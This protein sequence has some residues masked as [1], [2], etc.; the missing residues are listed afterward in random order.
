MVLF[1]S[2]D[3]GFDAGTSDRRIHVVYLNASTVKA[4]HLA[5]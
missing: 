3:A 4:K 5:I 1:L 2:V